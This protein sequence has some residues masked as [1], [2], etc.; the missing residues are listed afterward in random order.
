MKLKISLGI[1]IAAVAF[2]LYA[3]SI[4]FEYTLD[5]EYVVTN[6][7]LTKDGINSFPIILT[8]DY[9]YGY[10]R[11]NLRGPVYRPIPLLLFAT[12]WQFFPNNPHIGH[13]INV[14]LYS[15]LCWLLFLLLCKLFESRASGMSS[16]SSRL[17]LIP[18]VCTLLYLA[19]PIHTEV[20]DSIK[21]GDELLCF[22]FG[23]LA[24][25]L[26]LRFIETKTI[27]DLVLATISYFIA[28]MSKETGIVFIALTPLILFTFTTTEFKRIATITAS[29]LLATGVFF[30]IR[31]F[32]LQDI[33]PN[34]F[35]KFNNS[36]TAASDF[37]SQR[38]T[39]FYVL[40]RYLS[41]LIFPYPLAYDYSNYQLPNYTIKDL[42]P[43][44]SIIIHFAMGIYAFL[45]IRKKSLLS[46]AILF[47]LITLAP[48]SNIFMLIGSPMAERF[49]FIPSLGFCLA[50]TLLLM[51]LTKTDTAPL[52]G[53]SK[54]INVQSFINMN[55]VLFIIVFIITG[56]Y[57]IQ[58]FSRS[59]DWT[60]N[61][62]LHGHDV[63]ISPNSARM[64]YNWGSTL[65]NVMYQKET[66]QPEKMKLLDRA[67]VEFQKA[68]DILHDEM[69]GANMAIGFC[70]YRKED[71]ATAIKY[72]ELAL[73][74][75]KYP[76][77]DLINDLAC[78]YG[79]LNQYDKAIEFC[80]RVI[81]MDSTF[82]FGHQNKGLYLLNSGK[83]KE[84]IPEYEKTLAIDPNNYFAYK[85]LSIIYRKLG[86]AAKAKQYDDMGERLNKEQH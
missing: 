58:T 53:T 29:L 72:Y 52:E 14:L 2:I 68:I 54:L 67:I 34:Q 78:G 85:N 82:V 19:H 77:I 73:K 57:S 5:D 37:I 25:L 33:P 30:L 31:Y 49:L 21:S 20:V 44:I 32:V 38:A 64:H 36:I 45:T 6:N 39:S 80:D 41:L 70:Y 59:T 83:F 69:P 63:Q 23:I 55:P 71:Y 43:I 66:L 60:D 26:T 28:L 61:T 15:I 46:F 22:L 86:D 12:E 65:L 1:I 75:F 47:Y 84:A 48:V 40:L 11:D 18:F 56:I 4:S 8:S 9:F 35:M 50:I 17:Y 27:K 79:A 62:S 7:V 51:K 13:L 3:Q 81:K 24:I 10:R 76:S 16:L 42:L 74:Q